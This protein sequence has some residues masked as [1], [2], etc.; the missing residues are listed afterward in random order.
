[1]N[2]HVTMHALYPTFLVKEPGPAATTVSAELIGGV[3]GAILFVIITGMVILMISYI[4]YRCFC[5]TNTFKS[6]KEINQ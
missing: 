5:A 6:A 1:M 2:Y 3:V 4:C